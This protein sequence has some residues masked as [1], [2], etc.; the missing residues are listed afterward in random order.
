MTAHGAVHLVL[1]AG[2]W[3]RRMLANRGSAVVAL[4]GPSE[5]HGARRWCGRRRIAAM[6]SE[7]SSGAMYRA[8]NPRGDGLV[9]G[10]GTGAA[11]MGGGLVPVGRVALVALPFAFSFSLLITSHIFV[12]LDCAMPVVHFAVAVIRRATN[13][14]VGVLAIHAFLEI[15]RMALATAEFGYHATRGNAFMC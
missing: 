6:V 1:R 12:M 2:P 5:A 4:K 14:A 13:A 8:G 7:Q 11:L 3:L 9:D 10:D 15:K